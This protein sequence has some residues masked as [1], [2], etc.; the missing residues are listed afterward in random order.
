MPSRPGRP[1]S[2]NLS[3]MEVPHSL[4][5]AEAQ[6][7]SGGNLVPSICGEALYRREYCSVLSAEN[8]KRGLKTR[9]IGFHFFFKDLALTDKTLESYLI[10][11]PLFLYSYSNKQ[12]TRRSS[13][14]PPWC[15]PTQEDGR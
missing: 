7:D 10:T 3:W 14:R 11:K 13:T 9:T 6:S 1:H 4:P 5:A 8:Y 2:E 15:S 12:N